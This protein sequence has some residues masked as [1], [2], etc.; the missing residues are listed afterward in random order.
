MVSIV[1]KV[2][3]SLTNHVYIGATT[4]DL[5]KRKK[6]HLQKA[7]YKT[8]HT[9]QDAIK[10][11]GPEA[12]VWEQIDTAKNANELADKERQYVLDYKSNISGYNS[13]RGGGIKKNIY[14]YK[15]ENGELFFM[16]P[17]L[18]SAGNA[19]GVDKR[20]ISK[21]CLGEIKICA[22]YFWSYLLSANFEPEKDK[23]TKEVFQFSVDGKFINNFGSVAK[24]ARET[25]VNKSSIAKCCRGEYKSAGVYLWAYQR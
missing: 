13:D 9:F 4:D 20:T 10:T 7:D 3:N 23:R 25:G 2:T 14:Q 12:F 16:Y 22:G 11:Y 24:A 5:E 15:L 8:G 1:Y 6:D 19:M 21:A 17:D 18:Q